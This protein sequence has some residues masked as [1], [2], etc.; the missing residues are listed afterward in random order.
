MSNGQKF[1]KKSH[2]FGWLFL[3]QM[4]VVFA[5]V[6]LFGILGG[7]IAWG[8]WSLVVFFIKKYKA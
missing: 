3:V 2:P 6:K 7:I 8:I 5:I 1:S 4:I